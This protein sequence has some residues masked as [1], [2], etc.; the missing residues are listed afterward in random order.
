MLQCVG[1]HSLRAKSEVFGT[2]VAVVLSLESGSCGVATTA[3]TVPMRDNGET[4]WVSW[5]S[6]V[7]LLMT[8]IISN[9]TEPTLACRRT[10]VLAPYLPKFSFSCFIL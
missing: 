1:E 5:E 7:R 6:R 10:K 3:Q 4:C 8:Q 2:A 9:Q